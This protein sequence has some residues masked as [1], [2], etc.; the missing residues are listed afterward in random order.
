MPSSVETRWTAR[1][2]QPARTA[3][4]MGDKKVLV[5]LAGRSTTG[6]QYGMLESLPEEARAPI[7]AA[8][9]E[10]NVSARTYA[11]GARGGPA[12]PGRLSTQASSLHG[13]ACLLTCVPLCALS[14]VEIRTGLL[15]QDEETQRKWFG[16]AHAIIPAG[17]VDAELLDKCPNLALVSCGAVGY[18]NV[19]A[20][21]C[22]RRGVWVANA[23]G[24]SI[25]TT[26]DTALMLM[27]NIMRRG[28]INHELVRASSLAQDVSTR[29]WGWATGHSLG[30]DPEGKTLGIIGFGRIGQSLARKCNL[31]FGMK[32]IYYDV[33]H[34]VQSAVPTAVKVSMEELLQVRLTLGMSCVNAYR[35]CSV[36]VVACRRPMSSPCTST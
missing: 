13:H 26:S 23:G 29:K 9:D 34:I 7:Q 10:A 19:D 2:Q 8:L 17:L 5:V 30:D 22:A 16:E 25:D 15:S 18:D 1:Q 4:G 28:A 24:A 12:Q 31:A 14:Q 27:L 21:E 3:I 20:V 32:I 6:R 33:R 36:F 35:P 11:R